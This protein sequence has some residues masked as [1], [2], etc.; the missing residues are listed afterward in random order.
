MMGVLLSEMAVTDAGSAPPSSDVSQCSSWV[1]WS[2]PGSSGGFVELRFSE[3]LSS[4]AE[5]M[6]SSIIIIQHLL[7]YMYFTIPSR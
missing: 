5:T 3:G 4:T 2:L 1:G 6:G 7:T